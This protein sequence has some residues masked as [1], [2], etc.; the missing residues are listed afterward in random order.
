VR[1]AHPL[2]GMVWV[3][4]F[5]GRDARYVSTDVKEAVQQG[6]GLVMQLDGDAGLLQGRQLRLLGKQSGWVVEGSAHMMR[7]LQ[8]GLARQSLEK[9]CQAAAEPTAQAP[10]SVCVWGGGGGGLAGLGGQELD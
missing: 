10:V 1:K 6:V 5:V 3:A 8:K 2:T 9:E 7:G 4:C